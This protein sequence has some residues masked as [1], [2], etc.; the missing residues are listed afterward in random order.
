M[1]VEPVDDRLHLPWGDALEPASRKAEQL[2]F[3]AY[4]PGAG[5]LASRGKET[6]EVRRRVDGFVGCNRPCRDIK[7]RW[8]DCSRQITERLR[9]MAHRREISRS[10]F[11]PV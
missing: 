1:T 8:H 7:I 2:E 6:R 10:T 5:G 9:S 11:C 4:G 3:H